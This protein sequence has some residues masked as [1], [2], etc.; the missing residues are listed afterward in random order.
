MQGIEAAREATAHYDRARRPDRRGGRVR[1]RGRLEPGRGRLQGGLP[2]AG[3]LGRP[4][5]P[6]ALQRGLGAAPADRLQR[7]PE[8]PRR[9]RTT[10]STTRDSA[11]SAA[12]VQRRRRQHDPLERPLPAL[13]PL[14]LPRP[15]A[16]RRRRRLAAR[17][18]RAGAV[19]RPERPDDRRLPASTGDPSQPPR[20]PRQTPPIPLG[21]LGETMARGFDK[22]GWHWWPSDSGDHHRSRYG[23]PPAPATTAAPATSAARPARASSAD[24]TYW[25]LALRL[26]VELRTR[27]RVREIT[28]DEQGRAR[29]VALLRP[30]RRAPGA[31]RAAGHPRRQRRRHAAPA[32]QLALAPLPG[33]PGQPQRAGRQEP[34]VPPVRG[35]RR[36]LAET[37]SKATRGRSAAASSATSSTRPTSRAASCAA[38]SCRSCGSPARSARRSAAAPAPRVPWGSGHHAAFAERFGHVRQHRRDGRGPAR[39]GQRGHARPDPDR[40]DGIPAPL[41]R[42]R[43]SDNSLR[44]ARATA[45]PAPPRRCEAAGATRGP[46]SRNPLRPSG[47]HLLGTC[48]MGDDPSALGGRPLGPRARRP[49]PVHR[50]RQHLRHQRGRQ[51]D[52]DDP[53]A[54]PADGG[55]H[56]TVSKLMLPLPLGEGWGEGGS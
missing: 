18:R 46:R 41:V 38:S 21:P 34:D 27:C 7:R 10:R 4:D 52:D 31:A 36:R 29:G 1:R 49:E 17:L 19:L 32:A 16:R 35:G 47:W 11:F 8:R 15:L 25:P 53:G 42:Y 20:S 9:P 55:L 30:R 45:S 12:D 6:A 39:D 44:D 13:P 14:R 22:L 23:G 50:R 37:R 43:L 2:G 56:Q 24:V 40:R 51:P 28:V 26:G 3:R 48:R 33:R 54:R 5:D